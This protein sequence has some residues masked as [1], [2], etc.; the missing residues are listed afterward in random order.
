[1][2]AVATSIPI[3]FHRNGMIHL[4]PVIPAACFD[5]ICFVLGLVLSLH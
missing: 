5:Q 2:H 4:A 1:M 3:S